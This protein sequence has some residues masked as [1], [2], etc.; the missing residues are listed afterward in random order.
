MRRRVPSC[1]SVRR[2]AKIAAARRVRLWV[3]V[4]LSRVLGPI[5]Y[6]AA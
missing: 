4:T 1:H 2:V 6:F 5:R 3:Y